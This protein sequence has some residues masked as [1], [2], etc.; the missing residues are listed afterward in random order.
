[1]FDTTHR[2]YS[3]FFEFVS[4]SWIVFQNLLM[5]FSM[6]LIAGMTS[7][8]YCTASRCIKALAFLCLRTL[9]QIQYQYVNSCINKYWFQL[10]LTVCVLF[11]TH[12]SDRTP[13]VSDEYCGEARTIAPQGQLG[14]EAMT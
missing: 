6:S 2:D 5:S 3:V 7:E 4:V 1:M 14:V 13:K 11:V 10:T 8:S 9:F 12:A